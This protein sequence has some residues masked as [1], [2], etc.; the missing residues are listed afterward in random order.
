MIQNYQ[1]LNKVHEQYMFAI[2]NLRA[3]QKAAVI[4]T[5]KENT[6]KKKYQFKILDSVFNLFTW[7]IIIYLG[8]L[9]LTSLDIKTPFE[10]IKFEIKLADDIKTRLDDVKGID[11]IK[12]EIQNLIK[13]IKNPRK[14]RMKGAKLHKGVLLFGEPGVG[15]TLLARAIAGE[16]G[17]SFI[18]CTG[19]TF[20]EIFVGV[21]ARRVRQLFQTAKEH[22]P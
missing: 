9:F 10:S 5:Q 15:K 22:S 6:S 7:T 21:G 13:M 11:E 18:Y 12:Q 19:S 4:A 14:Y 2:E 3:L 1:R 16:S 20:D 17:V 8:L